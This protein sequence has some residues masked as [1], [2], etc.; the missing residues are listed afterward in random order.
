ME[1]VAAGG[2]VANEKFELPAA[3][4]DRPLTPVPAFSD[5]HAA[6]APVPAFGD[7][8]AAFALAAP[9]A[10]AAAVG[11]C[12]EENEAFHGGDGA[13]VAPSLLLPG[14]MPPPPVAAGGHA[15]AAQSPVAATD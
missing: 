12:A 5:G 4:G 7:G 14:N 15:V 9:A 6:F 2:D 1:D 10:T 11:L 3:P 13:A 8:H